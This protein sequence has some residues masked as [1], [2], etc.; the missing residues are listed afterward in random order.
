M[1]RNKLQLVLHLDGEWQRIDSVREAVGYS[2][3]ATFGDADLRDSL[4][5]VT[6]ELLENA[7]KYGDTAAGVQLSI[8]SEAE[9]VVVTVGNHVQAGSPHPAALQSRLDWLRQFEN[10]FTA[11]TTALGQVYDRQ[12]PDGT[13]SGL[14]FARIGYEGRCV[15]ACDLSQP[16]FVTVTAR[17][18][19]G[20]SE[21]LGDARSP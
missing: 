18:P 13:D 17:R 12:G 10:P 5:M 2:V 9:A 1:S 19:N 20:A 4:A 7:L 16:G 11:Y 15:V 14:G 21:A 3:A 6:A 8:V